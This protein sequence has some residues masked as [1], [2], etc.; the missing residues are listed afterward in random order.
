MDAHVHT[1]RHRIMRNAR[2]PHQSDEEAETEDALVLPPHL[3]SHGACPTTE[4]RCLARHV[5]RL[6]DEELDAFPAAEDLLYV[7]D[8]DVLYLGEL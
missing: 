3:S 2:H 1:V 4:G 8:H 6:V 7:L 5:I